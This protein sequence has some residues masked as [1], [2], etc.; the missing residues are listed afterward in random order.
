MLITVLTIVVLSFLVVLIG[1]SRF[2]YTLTLPKTMQTDTKTKALD[3][4]LYLGIGISLVVSVTN[5][6][7]VLFT[8]IDRKFIDLLSYTYYVDTTFSDVRFAIAS[9]VVMFP[10]Y[11]ALSWYVSRDIQKFLFKQDLWIRKALIYCTLF[12]TILSLIGALVSV[13]YT[14]LGGE[15]SVRFELKALS[16]FVVAISVFGYYF[17]TLRRDYTRKTYVP[18]IITALATG[19]VAVSIGWSISIIGT[20]SEMRAKKIDN[21]RLSDLSRIQQEVFNRFQMTDKLP[22]SLVELDNAFQGGYTV[23]SDPETKEVYGYTVLQQPTFKMN[24]VTNKK[25]MA[26]SAIF[27]LCATFTTTRNYDARGQTL[28]VMDTKGIVSGSADMYY[29]VSNYYYEGDQSPFW[30]HVAEKTCYKR[31]IGPEMYYGK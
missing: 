10:V 12:V 18:Y 7:Q 30:N 1:A 6:L 3:V 25:E 4:F 15:L 28:A 19:I 23:P 17:Y 16:V 26:T 9:L 14:Y 20:P 31:V 24:Y 2:F 5:I 27:E 29:S 11:I 8:A 13:V 21:I 22:L